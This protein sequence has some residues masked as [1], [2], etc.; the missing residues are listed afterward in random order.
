[1]LSTS[2]EG[3]KGHSPAKWPMLSSA[4]QRGIFFGASFPVIRLTL[5]FVTLCAT[6]LQGSCHFRSNGGVALGSYLI[7]DHQ[8]LTLPV[9]GGRSHASSDPIAEHLWNFYSNCQNIFFKTS[10][11]G[12]LAFLFKWVTLP[13]I[14]SEWI[15]PTWAI[16][17]ISFQALALHIFV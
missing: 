6:L 17:F 13:I 4:G 16:V 11:P 10:T 14:E 5:S 1:M 9:N 12:W 3:P 15:V 8:I 2:I 7:G